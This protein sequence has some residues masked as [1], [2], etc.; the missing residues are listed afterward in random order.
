MFPKREHIPLACGLSMNPLPAPACIVTAHSSRAGS[1]LSSLMHSVRIPVALAFCEYPPSI[2]LCMG[3]LALLPLTSSPTSPVGQEI[4]H[5]RDRTCPAKRRGE[6]LREPILSSP[7]PV[8]LTLC[9][10]LS[11]TVSSPH[12]HSHIWLDKTDI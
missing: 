6:P 12:S 9:F 2:C 8:S 5:S 10:F 3:S 4:Q 1:S 11:H 7:L